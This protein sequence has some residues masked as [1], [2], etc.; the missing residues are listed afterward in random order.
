VDD[1]EWG[2]RVCASGTPII[3]KKDVY[4]LH[5]PHQRDAAANRESEQANYR[6]FLRKWP[7]PDVEL[8][9]AFGD[10]EANRVFLDFRRELATVAGGRGCTLAAL[11]G[12]ANGN[13]VLI[14]GAAL[15]P[16]RPVPDPD[17]AALFDAGSR[18]EVVN[19]AG[20]ALPYDDMSVDEC[21]VLP[22]ISAFSARYRDAIRA[23]AERVAE[24]VILPAGA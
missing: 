12:T 3:L 16:G 19:L 4:G 22:P 2:F 5:L 8:A 9:H 18:I 10:V 24:T 20:L 23:E 21:R 6:R 13:Q 15:S 14:L 1:L 17:V 7:R 11:R